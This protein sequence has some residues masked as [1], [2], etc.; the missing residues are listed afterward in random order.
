MSEATGVGER[1]ELIHE[2]K[3][4]ILYK[5]SD[6]EKLI[7]Y[8]KDDAT[9]FNGKKKGT[10]EN[11]GVCN[12][13]I[14]SHIFII[15]ERVGVP[16]HFVEKVS[17]REMLVKRVE[18][19]PVEVVMRNVIAGSLAKRFGKEE[20]EPLPQP[21]LE[22]YYK[23]DSLNDPMINRSHIRALGLATD[24]EM[25][26]I[27]KQAFKINE[28]LVSFFD[29]MGIRLVDYKLEFG[30]SAEGVLLADEI[31]PDGCRLWDKETGEKM[32]KDRFRRDL[33]RLTE[34]YEEMRDRVLATT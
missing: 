5:T 29:K 22:Y 19:I 13:A 17:D 9:A 32:D 14:S 3:A 31:S 26:L 15:L 10:I 2:G 1:G 20:G 30:R 8:F 28:L 16:T 18:I 6:P 23:D 4:K 33:G 34:V 7:Q 11:K 25:D 24:E 27:E 21:V 12:N